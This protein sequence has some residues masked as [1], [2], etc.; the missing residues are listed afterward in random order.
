MWC[1]GDCVDAEF[2]G[3]E[4]SHVAAESG[5]AAEICEAMGVL[6]MVTKLSNQVLFAL[7]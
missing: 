4:V 1:C 3:T 2:I 7:W 5:G 6:V